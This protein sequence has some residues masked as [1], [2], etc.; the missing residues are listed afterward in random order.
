MPSPARFAPILCLLALAAA[1]VFATPK[2]ADVSGAWAFETQTYGSH[3][4][5]SGSMMIRP[6]G[7]DYACTFTAQERCSDI[8]VKAQESC[9]AKRLPDGSFNIIA[10]VNK[11]SPQVGYE[12]DNFEL[13]IES[14]AHMT[15]MLRS[16][17]SAP[18]DFFRG[19]APVS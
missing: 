17:H 13:K 18:V 11:V 19:D 12:P 9:E 1:P 6:A 10:T 8:T 2:A 5:L 16:F 15:G 7:K 14:G 3:C 4:Q